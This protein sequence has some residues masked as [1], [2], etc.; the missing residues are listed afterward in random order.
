L[1]LGDAGRPGNALEGLRIDMPYLKPALIP[2]RTYGPHQ[3]H[4]V[5]SVAVQ[6]LL[7]TRRD[8][9]EEL[10][11]ETTR[12]LFENKV[13][14]ARHHPIAGRLWEN[15]DARGL[16]FPFHEG[17]AAWYR[18]DDPSFLAI[19]APAM[20]LALTLLLAFGSAGLGA[21]EWLR[22][23][24]KD[25]IDDYYLKLEDLTAEL[26][27]G[28]SSAA[29]EGMR[30][31]LLALRR[32]AFHELVAEHLEANESFRIFQD[33][34]GA[35]MSEVDRLLALRAGSNPAPGS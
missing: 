24:K 21:R 4:P 3:P 2:A 14:L 18:R 26:H 32:D 35:Q 7:V 10:V 9:P 30:A 28:Q 29:L 33:F 27:A 16:R 23:E 6:A 25:R 13:S 1:T 31:D 15:A 34:L 11:R 5:G 22:R 8:V 19:Y 20:S 17:A 12:L